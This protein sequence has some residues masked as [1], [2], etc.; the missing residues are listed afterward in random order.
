MNPQLMVK[1]VLPTILI[2]AAPSDSPGGIAESLEKQGYRVY[3]AQDAA[4]GLQ[5]AGSEL[6]D[7]ILLDV[8][9]PEADGFEVCRRL[10]K[11]AATRDI[12][13]IFMTEP[14]EIMNKVTCFNAG[15]VDYLGK[16]L[17]VDEVIAS[18]QTQFN[19]SS[20]QKRLAIQNAQLQRYR[21]QL[22]QRVAER[23]RELSDSNQRLRKEIQ[24]RK[25]M[26]EQL[27]LKEFILDHAGDAVYL[28][29]R[30][31]RFI[32]VN[33]EAS[34]ALGYSRDELL[35]LGP[36]DIDPNITPQDT[37][38]FREQMQAAGSFNYETSH[39]RCDGSLFP[40]EIRG[41]LIEYQGQ[42]M[43]LALAR[44]ITERKR[45]EHAVVQSETALR[46]L[47]D[48]A[49]FSII[50]YDIEGRITYV[51]APLLGFFGIPLAELIG[52]LPCEV[53]TDGRFAEI[54]Q[55]IAQALRTKEEV[56][57]EFSELSAEGT[58]H[59]Q[60]WII[61]EKDNLNEVL[62]IIAFGL[63]ISERKRAEFDLEETRTQLRGLIAH[64]EQAREEERKLIAREVHDELGQI[65]SGLQLNIAL[66]A[67][68]CAAQSASLR[69]HFHESMI[70]IDQAIGVT[71]NVA[72]TLRPVEL[73][74]GIIASL[75]WLVNRFATY[76]GIQCE[77][78]IADQ[79]FRLPDDSSIALFRIVQ[80]SLTNVARHAHA[81]KLSIS[82][83]RDGDD[84]IL[85]VR[86]NGIGFDTSAKKMNS[87][88]LVGIRERT[89][90]LGGTLSIN[91]RTG[92]GTEIVVRIPC[93][94]K[95]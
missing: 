17:H 40:V 50:R 11:L 55:G 71:R 80:E 16:P 53:W 58:L 52:K 78:H 82:L 26:E 22:E 27:R 95:S 59:H 33:E 10:K 1:E 91:S 39:R 44:D 72:S 84:C 9:M 34:R 73:D 41:A 6:P 65:L 74:M 38:R 28:I 25:L 92:A 49:P 24:E 35:G 79:E 75:E 81:D 13:V 54:D 23:T 2:V 68:K 90:K 48:S 7:I 60:I 19:L 37:Q 63:D 69:E 45:I 64:R 47:T 56:V 32:Y 76:S 15:A 93:K 36:F 5:R 12:P 66:V 30:S 8:T 43:S 62:G 42:P 46:S 51:N 18:V 86:D 4:E 67:D 21:E 77:I 61:P 85:K 14:A 31:P 88:G 70:L 83:C 20:M 89:L 94:E 57:V 87:F 29:D 3:L